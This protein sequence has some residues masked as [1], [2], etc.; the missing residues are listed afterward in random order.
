MHELDNEKISDEHIQAYRKLG[1]M[2]MEY[3]KKR[4]IDDLRKDASVTEFGEGQTSKKS[5]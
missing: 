2:T 3:L 5:G 1:S 4:Q